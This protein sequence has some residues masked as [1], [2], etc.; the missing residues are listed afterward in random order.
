MPVGVLLTFFYDK[1]THTQVSVDA[2]VHK[3]NTGGVPA[4]GAGRG[5]P[6]QV[7]RFNGGRGWAA[8]PHQRS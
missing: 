4:G 8:H 6:E 3:H 2:G 5:H 1:H 7:L